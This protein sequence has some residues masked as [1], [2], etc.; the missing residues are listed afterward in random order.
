MIIVPSL[1]NEI[2]TTF[3][4]LKR[5]VRDGFPTINTII[6]FI[7]YEAFI[8]IYYIWSIGFWNFQLRCKQ[9]SMLATVAMV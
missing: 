7:Y 4:F 6:F 9:G 5:R 3:Y 1:A 2:T 8:D